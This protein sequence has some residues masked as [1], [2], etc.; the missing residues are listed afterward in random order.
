MVLN[1]ARTSRR[2]A[3]VLF[4]PHPQ[5]R[6]ENHGSPTAPGRSCP[7]SPHSTRCPGC[8][9]CTPACRA[10]HPIPPY[11]RLTR[12]N[13]AWRRRSAW[14]GHGRCWLT[15]DAGD[16]DG[17]RSSARGGHAHCASDARRWWEARQA[18]S[19][20]WHCRRSGSPCPPFLHGLV[21]NDRVLKSE[22][23]RRRAIMTAG[24]CGRQGSR[25]Q[26]ITLTCALDSS[27]V[28]STRVPLPG[29]RSAGDPAPGYPVRHRCHGCQ[30]PCGD[31]HRHPS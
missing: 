29:R 26:S 5:G 1:Q 21:G 2:E 14:V 13:W 18:R 16:C 28:G 27:A 9:R 17:V 4:T 6:S 23:A 10:L 12:R 8:W 3:A 31:C 30:R 15:P 24:A 7:G 25:P 22:C 20:K 11:R 19:E